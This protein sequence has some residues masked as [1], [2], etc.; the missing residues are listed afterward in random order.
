LR[1]I[2]APFVYNSRLRDDNG[3]VMHCSVSEVPT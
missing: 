1:K 2:A 3:L